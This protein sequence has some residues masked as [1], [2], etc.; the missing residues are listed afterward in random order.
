MIISENTNTRVLEVCRAAQAAQQAR[1]MEQQRAAQRALAAEQVRENAR[2]RAAYLAVHSAIVARHDPDPA[3]PSVPVPTGRG[4]PGGTYSTDVRDPFHA[5]NG[6]QVVVRGLQD[7]GNGRQ[8]QQDEFEIV[9][10]DNGKYI[11][12]LPGV[13]DLS[14]PHLGLDAYNRSVRDVDQGA[15]PSSTSADVRGNPYALMVE[16]YMRKNVPRGADV[17]IIGHSYGADTALDLA[18]DPSFNNKNTGFNITHV[19]AAAYFSQP[20]LKHVQNNTQVLVL[21]NDKD[22]PVL[23]EAAGYP[24]SRAYK[25]QADTTA[26]A[27]AF[28][29][30]VVSETGGFVGD[31][32]REGQSYVTQTAQEVPQVIDESVDT[33]K[34]VASATRKSTGGA[35]G[36]LQTGASWLG[37]TVVNG[38]KTEINVSSKLAQGD[39]RGATNAVTSAETQ[40]D[41]INTA[42]GS[43][44]RDAGSRIVDG[45]DQG[46]NA[47]AGWVSDQGRRVYDRAIA[48]P[49]ASVNHVANSGWQYANG[50]VDSA[51]EH[52]GKVLAE[53]KDRDRYDLGVPVP[54]PVGP[55]AL[56]LPVSG[57]PLQGNPGVS[58]PNGHTVVSRFDGGFSGAGHKQDNYIDYLNKTNDKSLQAYFDSVAAAGYTGAGTS[59][60]VDVSV[61]KG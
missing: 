38:V 55:I 16:A 52:G 6:E 11:V 49:V 26:E 51:L 15:V 42:A 8:I 18:S 23:A 36:I 7:T 28:E 61:P 25:F 59:T 19:T 30:S 29:R 32:L 21:Q 3:S 9:K 53:I 58:T 22:V 20:Q 33:A 27:G 45:V 47:T 41:E 40:Q 57:S 39:V 44:V 35:L 46:A 54:S 56:P 17:M 12:V 10:L 50:V 4:D 5:S 60:A 31:T 43:G 14:S 24:T 13:I 37:N 48:A 34:E 2:L 1:A